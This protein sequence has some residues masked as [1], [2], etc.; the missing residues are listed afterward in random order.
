MVMT[1]KENWTE[2]WADQTIGSDWLPIHW[3]AA[4][5]NPLMYQHIVDKTIENDD[6][7]LFDAY[8][9]GSL[10][11]AAKFSKFSMAQ[12]ILTHRHYVVEDGIGFK[13]DF[14]E[15]PLHFACETSDINLVQLLFVSEDGDYV[16]DD[17]GRTPLH[18]AARHNQLQAVVYLTH[19]IRN[20]IH[21]LDDD[22]IKV[23]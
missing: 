23:G 21:P 5:G 19:R 14:G 17:F 16:A 2:A 12:H 22:G 11:Y 8:G 10:H 1:I 7:F 20:N 18:T 13:N 6:E 4:H 15:T 3:L 9:N